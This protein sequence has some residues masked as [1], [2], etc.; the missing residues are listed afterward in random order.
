MFPW[1]IHIFQIQAFYFYKV[2]ELVIRAEEGLSRDVVKHLSFVSVILYT[3]HFQ[4][5]I[6]QIYNLFLLLT[7]AF[8]VILVTINYPLLTDTAQKPSNYYKTLYC[9]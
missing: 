1:V 2:I 4:Y 6:F 9:C 3:F 7:M 8:I 5:F